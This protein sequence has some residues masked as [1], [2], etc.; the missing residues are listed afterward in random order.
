MTLIQDYLFRQ[1]SR[2]V[3]AA[4]AALAGIGILSQS[5]DQLQ[6]IVED[7]VHEEGSKFFWLVLINFAAIFAAALALFAVLKIALVGSVG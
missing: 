1:M 3:L 6:V 2:P 5:L 7:Y 4:C